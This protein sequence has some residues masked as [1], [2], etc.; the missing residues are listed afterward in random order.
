MVI[1]IEVI[2][3][4]LESSVYFLFRVRHSQELEEL[5]HFSY[6]ISFQVFVTNHMERVIPAVDN[7][8]CNVHR[9]P[10]SLL[11]Q[12]SVPSTVVAWRT[13][14]EHI[15]MFIPYSGLFS[16]VEIFVKS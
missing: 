10:D 16:W 5:L 13:G 8:G 14:I 3:T 11:L 7:P 9:P 4:C 12:E 6:G 2:E 15:K 1:S